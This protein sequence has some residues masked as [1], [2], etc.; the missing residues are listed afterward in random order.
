[1]DSY[2]GGNV[3]MRFLYLIIGIMLLILSFKSSFSTVYQFLFGGIGIILLLIYDY[4]INEE[5][6]NY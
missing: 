2:R 3:D 4:K 5:I 1:M 6:W